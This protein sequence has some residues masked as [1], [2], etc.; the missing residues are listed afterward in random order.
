[1]QFIYEEQ[2]LEYM[3]R[4]KK[5]NIVI[6]VICINNSDFETTDLH[7]HFV[8][9]KQSDFYKEKKNYKG[10]ATEYGE[11]LL[12]PYRLEYDETIRF[13]LKNFLGIKSVKMKGV[14]L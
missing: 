14:R 4:K 11:V 12:P 2:L 5:N 1:M 3:K 6:E 13:G 10:I 7:V 9:E 8:N